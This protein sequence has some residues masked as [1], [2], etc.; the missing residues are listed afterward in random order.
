MEKRRSLNGMMRF[1]GLYKFINVKAIS[2]TTKVINTCPAPSM[3]IITAVNGI[4][5]IRSAKKIILFLK[6]HTDVYI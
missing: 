3:L 5:R 4:K 1:F 2:T 6:T